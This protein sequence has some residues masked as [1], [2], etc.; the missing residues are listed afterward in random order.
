MRFPFSF[1]FGFRFSLGFR[2]RFGFG[3]GFRLGC[4][5]AFRYAFGFVFRWAGRN[6]RRPPSPGQVLVARSQIRLAHDKH[7][8]FFVPDCIVVF[9]HVLHVIAT[10]PIAPDNLSDV[11]EV[12]CFVSRA[13]V[14]LGTH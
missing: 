8:V 3:L 2:F 11:K 14:D 7:A 13:A 12:V 5:L 10:L 4:D 6:L 9:G 1:G